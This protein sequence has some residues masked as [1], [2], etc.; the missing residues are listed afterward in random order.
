MISRPNPFMRWRQFWFEASS[1]RTVLV[2]RA[3]LCVIAGMYFANC[4]SDAAL[5]TSD[6]GPFSLSNMASFVDA[7]GLAGET[8]WI[9]S[10]L[11]LAES[12]LGSSQWIS[13]LYLLVGIAMCGSV[14]FGVGGRTVCWGLWIVLIGWANRLLLVSGLGESLLSMALL[15]AAV[16]P[17]G[18]VWRSELAVDFHWTANVAKRLLQLQVTLVGA[19][20]VAAMLSDETWWDTAGWARGSVLLL[21]FG[22]ALAWI[23]TTKRLGVGILVLWGV[24]I[25]LIDAHWLYGATFAAMSL[26]FWRSPRATVE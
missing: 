26:A 5:W 17:S 7:A 16:A 3:V 9:P 2:V 25:A 15:A 10:P 18:C 23:H 11:Y 14:L 22:L 4:F 1:L 21:P 13:L 12:I 6:A 19:T 24:L 8:R 20:M